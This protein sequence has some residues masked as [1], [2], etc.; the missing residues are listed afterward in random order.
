MEIKIGEFGKITTGQNMGHYVKVIDDSAD[1]GGFLIL[2]GPT[3]DLKD[4]YDNWVEDSNA[5]Q[6]YFTEAGWRVLWLV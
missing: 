1:T 6:A 4:C 2:T 3:S 5:L